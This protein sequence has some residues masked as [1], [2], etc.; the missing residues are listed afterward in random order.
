MEPIP[1]CEGYFADERGDIYCTLPHRGIKPSQPRRIRGNDNGTGYLIVN[2]LGKTRLVHRLVLEAFSGV[3]PTG[4]EARHLNGDRK[5][6]RLCNLAWGTR[7]E[8][9]EDK[10]RHA[11]CLRDLRDEDRQ[12]VVV[13]YAAGNS[14]RRIASVIGKEPKHIRHL[15]KGIRQERVWLPEWK[16]GE[17][18]RETCIH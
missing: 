17:S 5:D 9:I 2:V 13:W 11:E 4:L 3:C 12:F 6:N 18:L 16:V 10:K 15:V 8:N 7:E 14:L 1:S